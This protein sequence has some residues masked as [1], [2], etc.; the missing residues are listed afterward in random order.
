MGVKYTL[1]FKANDN[2]AW[3]VDIGSDV[4]SVTPK[5]TLSYT[6]V[7]QTTPYSINGTLKININSVLV[8]TLNSSTTKSLEIFAGLPYSFQGISTFVTG[9]TPAYVRL[10]ITKNASIIYQNF[11]FVGD[12]DSPTGTITRS[13]IAQPG[14]VYT[15]L[16]ETADSFDSEL[17]DIPDNT[18]VTASNPIVIRGV[19]EQAVLIAHDVTETDDP[20]C[21]LIP[22]KVTINC[23]NQGNINVDEMQ[24]ANSKDFTVKI[25][26][27]GTLKW[28]G[29]LNVADIQSPMLSTPVS[30]ALS[31]TDGLDLLAFPYV[32]ADLPGT[33]GTFSRC[34]MN[35]IRQIL[36]SN[37]GVTLPI[38]WTN[39]LECTAFTEEDVFTGGVQWAVNG[40]GFSSYQTTTS[41]D[42]AIT[43]T[44]EYILTG[45]LQSMQSRIYQENGMWVIRRVPDYI[46][47]NITYKQI[48]GD[49]G[50][51]AVQTAT[52]NVLKHIGRSGGY[53]FVNEDAVKT[54][55]PGLKSCT[56]TYN[57]NKRDNILPNGSQ[58]TLDIGGIKPLYWGSYDPINLLTVSGPSLDLRTGSSTTIT[59][60]NGVST[61][62][63]TLLQDGGTFTNDG[64]PIDTKTLIKKLSFGFNF[65]PL[66][67]FPNDV[68]SHIIDWSS[69][70]F[71]IKV[72]FNAGTT[73]YYLTPFGFWS[74][75][76]TQIS[77]IVDGLEI[78]EVAKVDFDKFQ[79]IL[80]PEPDVPLVAGD[81]SDLQVIFIVAPGQQYA[82]DYIYVTV[83]DGNDV[84]ESSFD[85]S[86]NTDTDSREI[87]ISSSFGGYI[88]NNLM[89]NWSTS[90]TECFYRDGFVYEGTLTGL[91]ANAIMRYRYKSS[92]IFN[93]SISTLN[94]DWSFDELYTIDSLGQA[95]FL[96]LNANYNVEKCECSIVA[97]ES[98]NDFISLT[99]KFYSSNDATLS[100]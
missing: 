38:R 40:E 47:G 61:N 44:C 100:N 31:A 58:D 35:Y 8:D 71:N 46:R 74:T 80:M 78:G 48:A 76:D 93:G 89:T 13:G 63:F 17:I 7:E 69:N 66:A 72:I 82:L 23:L 83:D 18:P 25:Y 45:L 6:M 64:L 14:A 70:P 20:F 49:L 91:T 2:V 98:R 88:L 99:E 97:M 67:G 37:L 73:K 59:N 62:Y 28:S 19:S 1:P 26:R 57:F 39:T 56:V 41:G 27:L 94:G 34:P 24:T 11:I 85:N 50:I 3:R 4:Y 15:C 51:M 12:I 52:Q 84:Y 30:L 33:T 75:D 29:F 92:R 5:A 79:G 60:T 95:K 54:V 77:I 90:D 53:R 86:K 81:I 55:K 21:A 65:E 42:A 96:L 9:H 43:Q 22:S 36:F 32:H 16:V 10:T 68:I 87:N